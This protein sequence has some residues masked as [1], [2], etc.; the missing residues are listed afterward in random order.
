MN[1]PSWL[2]VSRCSLQNDSRFLALGIYSLLLF[3][4]LFSTKKMPHSFGYRART[5]D[6]FARP[7]KKH[8]PVHLSK[9]LTTYRIGDHVDVVANGA[10]HRG[11]PHRYYHGKTGIVWNV[12]KRAIGV[13]INK[14]VGT[15]ILRKR[16]HVRVEHVQ[17]SN[18]RTDFL[19]RVKANQKLRV[20][21]KSQKSRVVLKRT[22][23]NP[24]PGRFVH[25]NGKTEVEKIAALKYEMLF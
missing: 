16:I 13:I 22:A 25:V 7:Y 20:D 10:I 4:C 3:W 24:K 14:R 23:G 19:N 12:T 9:Y 17:P 1:K 6:I 11:M 18:C 21:A 8:G 15:R 5:R 2:W